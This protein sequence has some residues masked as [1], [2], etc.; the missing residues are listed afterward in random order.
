MGFVACMATGPNTRTGHNPRQ[1]KITEF[2]ASKQTL[3]LVQLQM[4]ILNPKVKRNLT[5]K[6]TEMQNKKTTKIHIYTMFTAV[7]GS[8]RLKEQVKFQ[9]LNSRLFLF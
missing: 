2:G 9:V 5:T 1:N 6:L 8:Y 3:T 4:L 7:S